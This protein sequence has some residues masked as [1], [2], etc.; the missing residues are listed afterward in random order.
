MMV[1]D[2]EPMICYMHYH[3]GIVF[4]LLNPSTCIFIS[5][6]FRLKFGHI[7]TLFLHLIYKL[8]AQINIKKIV[9]E[10]NLH[11]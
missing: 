9:Y 1:E 10:Q 6:D 4:P 2:V 7:Y 3:L 11:L 8:H 5:L